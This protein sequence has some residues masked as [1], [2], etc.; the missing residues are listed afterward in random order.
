[1]DERVVALEES[2]GPSETELVTCCEELEKVSAHLENFDN[3]GRRCNIKIIGLPESKEGE[4]MIKFLQH[5]LP[6][7]LDHTFRELEIQHAHQVGAPRRTQGETARPRSMMVH[8]FH[9]RD[10]EE[11]FRVAR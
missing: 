10:K 9:Y 7:T 1:M 6:V 5:E 11:I 4:E 3:R 8:M 2:K